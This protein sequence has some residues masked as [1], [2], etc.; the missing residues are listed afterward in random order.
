MSTREGRVH[1]WVLEVHSGQLHDLSE[2]AAPDAHTID[3]FP[4]W[5]PDGDHIA[6]ISSRE[7][8]ADVWLMDSD[9]QGLQRLTDEGTGPLAWSPDGQRLAVASTRAD[10]RIQGV[11]ESFERWQ[12]AMTDDVAFG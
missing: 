3:A 4:A 8:I 5:S 6:F 7:G 9:G 11:E 1:L 2:V 12:E 10:Q